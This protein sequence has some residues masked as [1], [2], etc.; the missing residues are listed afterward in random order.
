MILLLS[1][2]VTVILNMDPAS[3][4]ESGGGGGGG[5]AGGEPLYQFHAEESEPEKNE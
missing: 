3:R 5:G 1:C 2:G 4:G